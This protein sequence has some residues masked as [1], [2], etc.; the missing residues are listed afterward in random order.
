MAITK[1]IVTRYLVT[2]ENDKRIQI[3]GGAIARTL[4]MGAN[5]THLRIGMRWSTT[6][7]YADG[8]TWPSPPPFWFGI[9]SGKVNVPGTLSPAHFF[10][11]KTRTS[12]AWDMNNLTNLACRL[13]VDACHIA[14]GVESLAVFGATNAGVRVGC[15]DAAKNRVS[16][17]ILDIVKGDPTWTISG[18]WTA[19]NVT[20]NGPTLTNFKDAMNGASLLN[21]AAPPPT[22]TSFSPNEAA[23]GVL[24]TLVFSFPNATFPF[25][26]SDLYPMRVS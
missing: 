6:R 23:H 11:I 2:G 17:I 9:C 24:D 4:K 26:I 1:N 20:T 18:R 22:D 7:S 10:G 8:T 19:G 12:V 16:G 14:A 3:A 21:Q 5:W 13:C 15:F 25:E